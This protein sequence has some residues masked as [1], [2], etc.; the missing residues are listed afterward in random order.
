MF[1]EVGVI[2]RTFSGRVD[3]RGGCVWGGGVIWKDERK[4]RT[5]TSWLP[6]QVLA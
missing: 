2:A 3:G 4:D 6:T 5:G 1:T